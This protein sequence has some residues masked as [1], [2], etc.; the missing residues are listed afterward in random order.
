[1][2][3]NR[4]KHT[5]T[6][7]GVPLGTQLGLGQVTAPGPKGCSKGTPSHGD[8]TPGWPPLLAQQPRAPVLRWDGALIPEIPFKV[9]KKNNTVRHQE[10]PG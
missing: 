10:L 4:E 3:R 7:T 6:D 8:A 1:M 2:S 5:H 9:V